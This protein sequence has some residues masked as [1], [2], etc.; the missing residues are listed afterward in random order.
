KPF[1][2]DRGESGAAMGKGLG[3]IVDRADVGRGTADSC[4]NVCQKAYASVPYIA[5][6]KP[7]YRTLNGDVNHDITYAYVTAPV[8]PQSA[9]IT[10]HMPLAEFLLLK[11]LLSWVTSFSHLKCAGPGVI[12][13]GCIWPLCAP[14]RILPASESMTCSD[15]VSCRN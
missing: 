10:H 1:T 6:D 15:G 13:R 4:L 7:S 3:V 8:G 5:R 11:T 2:R 12:E 14:G 9:L